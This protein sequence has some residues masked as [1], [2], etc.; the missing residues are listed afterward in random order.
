M[1]FSKKKSSTYDFNLLGFRLAQSVK[2]AIALGILLGYAIQFFV[3]I[4]I[5]FPFVRRSFKI[6]DNHSFAGE[7][8]FRT[9]LVLVTFGIAELVPNLSLLLSLFGAVCSTVI[10]L[11]FPPIIEFIILSS[12]DDGVSWFVWIRNS[13]ILIVSLVGFLTG[14]YESISRIIK[15]YF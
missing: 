6:V 1:K 11:V 12:E 9:F 5:M 13:L 3:T 15:T 8:I 14:G 2:L 4:E 7:M 10:A